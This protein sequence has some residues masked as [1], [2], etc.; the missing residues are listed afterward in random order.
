MVGVVFAG[1]GIEADRSEFVEGCEAE[2]GGVGVAFVAEGGE[3]VGVLV[4]G[5]AIGLGDNGINGST[6]G[7][8]FVVG[9]EDGPGEG[10]FT[11]FAP[12]VAKLLTPKGGI[13]GVIAG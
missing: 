8:A 12:L 1:E 6:D 7:P 4:A 11:R 9:S 10:R 5:E 2:V 13:A 3:D